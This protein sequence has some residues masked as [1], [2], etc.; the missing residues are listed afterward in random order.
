M[1]VDQLDKNYNDFTLDNVMSWI[2]DHKNIEGRFRFFDAY[3]PNSAFY[4]RVA[5]PLLSMYTTGSID[6]E[7]VAKPFKRNLLRKERNRLSDEKGI[8]LFRAAQNLKYLMKAKM[9]VK[10]TMYD[11]CA[12]RGVAGRDDRA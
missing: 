3:N 8:V 10:G 11:V 9:A 2:E 4:R 7:G 5:R 1:S 6:V 12:K